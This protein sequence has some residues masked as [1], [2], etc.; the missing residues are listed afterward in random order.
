MEARAGQTGVMCHHK[1]IAAAVAVAAAAA[2]PAAFVVAVPE[3]TAVAA[4]ASVV[5]PVAVQQQLLLLAVPVPSRKVIG[6]K[7]TIAL[8]AL[9]QHTAQCAAARSC[10]YLYLSDSLVPH[11]LL[12]P[13]GVGPL[14]VVFILLL[15]L[16][17][18]NTQGK[19][20]SR[21]QAYNHCNRGSR[22]SF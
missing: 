11:A 21:M 17:G 19:K 12:F 6:L 5:V 15:Q 9:E 13:V 16:G 20:S 14:Y 1:L 3:A 8:I 4:V 7:L 10:D 22:H 18:K 2:L